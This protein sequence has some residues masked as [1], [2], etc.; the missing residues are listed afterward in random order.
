MNMNMI[1]LRRKSLNM[2]T[3]SIH[4]YQPALVFVSSYWRYKMEIDFCFSPRREVI[5]INRLSLSRCSS[6]PPYHVF[7]CLITSQCFPILSKG[8]S[9]LGCRHGLT[10]FMRDRLEAKLSILYQRPNKDL[11]SSSMTKHVLRNAFTTSY[12]TGSRSDRAAIGM[13]IGRM[14]LETCRFRSKSLFCSCPSRWSFSACWRGLSILLEPSFG[15]WWIAFLQGLCERL[16]TV[17][18]GPS[19][20]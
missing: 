7:D 20:R 13:K 9:T 12:L 2:N 16:A 1:Q 6:L 15:L 3:C 8:E 17:G 19:W 4:I 14:C 5:S 10:G 11:A 18:V